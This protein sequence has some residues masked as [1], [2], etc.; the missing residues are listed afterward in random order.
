[1]SKPVRLQFA[2][3]TEG[4]TTFSFA[5]VYTFLSTREVRS[6]QTAFCVCRTVVWIFSSFDFS[7]I[8]IHY[9]CEAL[10]LWSNTFFRIEWLRLSP[11]SPKLEIM[12]YF[13]SADFSPCVLSTQRYNFRALFATKFSVS[14]YSYLI[15]AATALT[16]YETF[17]SHNLKIIKL[18]HYQNHVSPNLRDLSCCYHGNH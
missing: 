8:V 12:Y 1:M 7:Y 17:N 13:H 2:Y 10:F 9:L 18:S 4:G 16:N 15:S 11:L 14:C 6:W 5:S 3:Q